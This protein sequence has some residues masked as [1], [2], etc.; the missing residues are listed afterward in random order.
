MGARVI[1]GVGGSHY[2]LYKCL[3]IQALSAWNK[4]KI[5]LN[6]NFFRKWHSDLHLT[7][8][9]GKLS[10]ENN[11]CKGQKEVICF[12]SQGTERKPGDRN[13]ESEWKSSLR[14]GWRGRQDPK[15][16]R[17]FDKHLLK[18]SSRRT[19]SVSLWTTQD[20]QHYFTLTPACF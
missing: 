6:F 18:S 1:K 16:G 19:S 7:G 5:K 14:W 12:V 13:I 9:L 15:K 17:P 11:V 3:I 20:H 4:C 8:E 10:Q 2:K